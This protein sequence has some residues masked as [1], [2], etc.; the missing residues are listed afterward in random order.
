MPRGLFITGTDTGVGKTV[1]AAMFVLALESKGKSV[2]AMKPIETGCTRRGNTLVPEDG[3][4]LRNTARMDEAIDHVTPYRFESRVSPM[5]ASEREGRKIDPEKI[6]ETFEALRYKNKFAI[7]EGAG[8]LLAPIKKDYFML[9][10]ARDLGLALVV[11]A[12]PGLGTIN[13]TLLTVKYAMNEGVK[14]AGI[15]INHSSEPENSLAEQTNPDAI[16]RLSP[17]PVIGIAPY[18]EDIERE[19]L[20]KAASKHLDLGLIKKYI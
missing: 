16:S 12:R 4:F 13:H 18:L 20:E 8:G 11:V 5:A 2:F 10:M 14:V 15:V 7:V 3:M 9:D 6:K 19:T 17:A 1:V